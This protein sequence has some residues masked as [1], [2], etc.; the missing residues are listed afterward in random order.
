MIPPLEES[1]A[2]PWLLWG[3]ES[4]HKPVAPWYQGWLGELYHYE[5]G[6]FNMP[7]VHDV[8]HRQVR[9]HLQQPRAAGLPER[10]V[11]VVLR[12]VR[13]PPRRLEQV[14]FGE[15]AEHVGRRLEGR[16]PARSK[17]AAEMSV[18]GSAPQP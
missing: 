3:V 1:H 9:A 2:A 6:T 15:L 18:F 14:R 8:D 17:L 13:L 4:S 11:V 5:D 7:P 16:V 12:V 10:V